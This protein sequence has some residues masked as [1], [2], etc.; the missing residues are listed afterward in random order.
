MIREDNLASL[1]PHPAW[2]NL[3]VIYLSWPLTCTKLQ[4]APWVW[5]QIRM[6]P[7]ELCNMVLIFLPQQSVFPTG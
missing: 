7:L 5:S 4:V 6:C 2:T 1:I 3:T